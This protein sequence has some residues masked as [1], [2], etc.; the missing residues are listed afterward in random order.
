MPKPDLA[1]HFNTDCEFCKV[2][3]GE[4]PGCVVFEDEVSLAFLDP[5]KPDAAAAIRALSGAGVNVK[6]LTGDNERITRQIC[7][8]IGVQTTGVLTGQELAHLNEDA[9]SARLASVN[10]FCRVTPQQKERILLALTSRDILVD[11][12]PVSQVK[13]DGAV[14]LLQS[15]RRK[16]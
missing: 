13:G 4:T 1:P 12:G 15:Q 8:E 16:R 5:P 10:L 7:N 6:I 9:L 14:D 11:L 3:C 2:V